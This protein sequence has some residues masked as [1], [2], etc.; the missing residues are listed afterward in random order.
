MINLITTDSIRA[1]LKQFDSFWGRKISN[2]QQL[3][4][5][6]YL[7]LSPEEAQ[8]LVKEANKYIGEF[9]GA[10][11][12]EVPYLWRE[13]SHDCDNFAGELVSFSNMISAR[14]GGTSAQPAIFRIVAEN[15]GVVHAYNIIFT[16]NGI[17]FVDLTKG[18][19]IWKMKEKPNIIGFG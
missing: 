12:T 2:T 13:M 1:Q 11:E 14:K 8:K 5:S 6:K 4:D 16:S 17:Y 18:A 19:D 15:T 7:L 10:K 3:L 9:F